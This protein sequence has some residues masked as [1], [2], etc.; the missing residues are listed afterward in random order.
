LSSNETTHTLADERSVFSALKSVKSVK[1][2]SHSRKSIQNNPVSK[3]RPKA[4]M[5][6][7]SDSNVL[8][9]VQMLAN[10]RGDAAV[11]TNTEG[12][13][14]GIVTDTDITRRLV[15]KNLPAASTNIASIMTANPT[16]VSM[17]DAATE[18]LVTMV[19]NRFRHLP[20]TDESGIVV[21]VLDIAKC[22]NDAISK[23]ERSADKSHEAA[24]DAIKQISSLQGA[25]GAQSAM[26]QQLLGP[27]LAQA[28][29]GQTS[30]TL[31]SMLVG[32]PSTAVS[33]DTSL[34]EVG[35]IMAEARK[36][37]LV[38][39]NEKL[40]GIF[41]F[42]DMMSRAIAKELPLHLTQVSTVMTPNPESVSPDTT[43]LEALQIMHDNKFLTLPVCESNGKVIGVVDV[44]DCVYASGGAEGWRS[45]FANAMECDSVTDEASVH[46]FK[47]AS[48]SVKASMS[49]ITRK[50][51]NDDVPVSKLRPKNP[52]LT[53]AKDS[54]LRVCQS[55]SS[56][57][58]DAALIVDQSGSLIG[59][60]TD[61]DI[62]RRLVAKNLESSSTPA[63]VIMTTNPKC[64]LI[65]DSALDAL[66]IMVE[67]RFR[68]LPVTDRNGS[69]VG[70]LDIAKCL[71]NAISK[72]E[73]NQE[74]TGSA[75]NE[76]VKLMENLQVQGSQAKALSILLKQAI[77][78]SSCSTLRSILTG[79]PSTIVSPHSTIRTVGSMMAEAR[80]A[81]LVVED[82]ELI[83]IFGFKDMMTRAIAKD[84]P[85]DST[86]VSS[87]MTP[88]PESVSPE[89][90]VLEALQ[91]M[92][93]N[94]FLTLPVCED[95]G[96]VLGLVD[97]MDCVC[98]VG[99]AEK[100]RELF[101]ST[102]NQD[103]GSS[104]VS[105]ED[106]VSRVLPRVMVTSHPNS[107][108]LH[109]EVGK[110]IS[111]DD[112]TS[113]GESLTQA[114]PTMSTSGSPQLSRRSLSKDNQAA[115]KIVDGSGHTFIIRAATTIQ[116]ILSAL[117]GK[118][119]SLDPET[120]LFKYHDEEGDEIL[121]KSND[122]LEE[123]VRL[124]MLAGNKSVKLSMMS[125]AASDGS[126]TLLLAGG[127]GLFA[128]IGAVV[129]LKSKK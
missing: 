80:K 30:P 47:S 123:A 72:L 16:C 28:F 84:L 86:P 129:M 116:S 51:K 24:E 34:Q 110:D 56:H 87:V 20:V 88:S 107:I 112:G 92:Y 100:W 102:L 75:A 45:I 79:N 5:V 33:P 117:E 106:S 57:R 61:T 118:V 43:V 13:L 119:A 121:I 4:P 50:S 89:T 91:I 8:S 81:A 115:F 124:S 103:D 53:N 35:G 96:S 25:R 12:G 101:Y 26:V 108:P 36:A 27:I 111:G 2:A 48:R 37:A 3:L 126:R 105:N 66:A 77:G 60:I 94:R 58:G 64:V 54:V 9:V 63:S 114:H 44:M 31:R 82:N 19:E 52:I 104:V 95:D 113:V 59:L 42:K 38:V 127:L 98:A 10:K 83:G 74:K 15:A 41:G 18:A 76:A 62:T 93:D 128:A 1:T 68:H 40:V 85:L 32:K 7:S 99:G 6:S 125:I 73:Q 120:T 109:V 17:S 78:G 39:K 23:L 11:I 65:T 70:V 22:L 46:S 49:E 69:V 21:G 67:N 97:V 90:T 14:A 29:G 122:C 71:N 55:L